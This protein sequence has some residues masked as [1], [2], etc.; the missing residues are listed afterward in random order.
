MSLKSIVNKIRSMNTQNVYFGMSSPID[1]LHEKQRKIFLRGMSKYALE[2]YVKKNDIK[3]FTKLALSDPEDKKQ[4]DVL[5]SMIK[6]GKIADV[7]D[8]SM[9]SKL[10]ENEKL[11]E[12]LGF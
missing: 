11:L 6:S 5:S 4:E 10:S 9:A 7:L 12:D 2:L 8:D 1:D 3:N